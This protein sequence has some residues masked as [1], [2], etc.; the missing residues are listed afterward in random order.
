MK[1]ARLIRL[2]DTLVNYSTAVKP[3][4]KVLIE[5]KGNDTLTLTRE[6]VSQVA[7]AGGLPFWY[8]N[9]EETERRWIMGATEQ[10]IKDYG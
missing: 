8:H 2:A 1:D 9:D 5:T 4:D 10:Q 7:A 3:G 6:I